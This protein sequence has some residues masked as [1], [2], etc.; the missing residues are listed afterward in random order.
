MSATVSS[1]PSGAAACATA[2]F[3]AFTLGGEEYGIDIQ[4]V[5]E[6]RGYDSVTRLAN[7]PEF[8][9]GVVNLRGVIVPII[10]MRIKFSGGP[11][12]YNELTVVIVLNLGG[13]TI[14]MVV[15]SVSDVTTLAID[16]IKPAPQ[17]GAGPAQDYLLGLGTIDQR[18]LILLDAERLMGA[19]DIGLI[20]KLAA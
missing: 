11:A 18:M 6:L 3:F 5:Q 10:D 13:R 14:G 15:D 7:A 1:V 9:K 20:D 17:I 2:Q 4:K 12:T 16:D 8:I 19:A